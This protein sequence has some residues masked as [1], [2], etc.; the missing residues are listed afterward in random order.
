[1]TCDHNTISGHG[2]HNRYFEKGGCN[3]IKAALLLP[4]FSL[5][6]IS[7]PG[8]C[9][10]ILPLC[11][12]EVTFLKGIHSLYK[13]LRQVPSDMLTAMFCFP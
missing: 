4:Y 3:G 6:I 1:M 12:L 10:P 7:G 11:I 9:I 5:S 8:C 13:G 2:F